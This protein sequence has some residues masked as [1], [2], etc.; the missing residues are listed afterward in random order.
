MFSELQHYIPVGICV[1]DQA[2]TVVFANDFLKNRLP[3]DTPK[4]IEG[5]SIDEVFPEA[6]KIIKRKLKSVFALKA[7]SFS[8]WEHRPHVFELSSSRPVTGDETSMYQNI[9]YVPIFEH[10]EEVKKVCVIIQDV[11]ELASYYQEQKRL[12]EALEIEKQ[13][14]KT[15]NLKLEAA[16]NQLLQSEKMAAIGQLA[17]GVA[18]EINN[19]IGFVNSNIQSLEGQASGLFA[20]LAF[21]ETHFSTLAD[22]D[23]K[24]QE[25]QLKN[26]HSID[27]LTEDVPELLQECLEGLDRV[28]NIV[29][30]L[31]SFSHV[32]NQEWQEADLIKGIESTLKIAN[33]SIKYHAV[34]NRTYSLDD[35]VL[36][37]CQP[38][39]INQVFLNLIINAAQSIESSGTVTISIEDRQ[40]E[41]II[42]IQDTGKGIPAEDINKIFNPFFTTKPVG[43]GT[44]LGLSL[45]YSIVAK[46]KG[47]IKVDSQVGVG[48]TFTVFLP[49]LSE[50]DFSDEF[51]EN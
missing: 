37:Y 36:L 29:E 33:N 41:V 12:T 6:A 22:S 38:M 17:A 23:L 10:S 11:T 34:I 50:E 47:R 7:A 14:L 45:S 25:Q 8:Y 15:L 1:L 43:Q 48:T 32:D 26:Q 18:H 21:Y 49:K 20:M 42:A 28:S 46:H 9:Q 39:Q 5:M 27:F 40:N 2:Y 51:T 44:G 24:Q 31:K 19:P 30:S 4:D 13:E 35:E 16:Q 3:D